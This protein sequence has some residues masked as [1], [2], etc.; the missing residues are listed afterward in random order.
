MRRIL[1]LALSIGLI[2]CG[3]MDK[4][5]AFVSCNGEAAK[6]DA[7]FQSD[8][9][10]T[11]NSERGYAIFEACMQEHGYSKIDGAVFCQNKECFHPATIKARI[12]SFISDNLR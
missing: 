2:G 12:A 3:Q 6:L 1:I 5:E 11:V 10:G 4:K 7:K 9:F 8:L